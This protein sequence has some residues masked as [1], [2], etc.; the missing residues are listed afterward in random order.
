MAAL[1]RLASRGIDWRRL[2]HRIGASPVTVTGLVMLGIVVFCVG[3]LPNLL[4]QDPN[5]INLR[6][7]LAAP[8]WSHLFGT[9]EVGRDIFIRVLHGGQ[10]SI[11]VALFVVAVSASVGT[12]IGGLSGLLGGMVDTAIMRLMDVVL[13]VPSLVLT[14]ALAAALGPS[15][16]NAVIAIAVVRVPTY[17]RLSR[18]Q[19]L[20]VREAGYVMAARVFGARPLQ[21]LRLHVVPNILSPV[22]VQATLDVGAVILMVAGLSFIGLGAQPPAAEWGAMVSAGRSFILDQWWYSAFPGLA[23][24]FTSIAFNLLGDGIRDLTDPRQKGRS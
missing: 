23:I 19:T 11:G 20:V 7:R 1:S 21:I 12:V 6:A 13:A 8:S 18:G 9:D 16:T 22:V 15:L 17:V 5:V 2:R 3:L 14:M 4:A 10:V 24:L